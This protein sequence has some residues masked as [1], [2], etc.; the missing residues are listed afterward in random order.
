MALGYS[1]GEADYNKA[2]IDIS[3]SIRVNGTNYYHNPETNNMLSW[4]HVV[5]A[6]EGQGMVFI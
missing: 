6:R 2:I 4:Q 3:F 1:I 5:M